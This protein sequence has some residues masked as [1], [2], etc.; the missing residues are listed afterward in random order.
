MTFP[1]TP[2]LPLTGAQSG[3][4]FDERLSSGRLAYNMADYLD[5]TGPLDE[6]LLR[7][8]LEM[9]L[10]EAECTRARFLEVDGMPAQRIEPLGELPLSTLDLSGEADPLAEA[11]RR[12]DEDLHQPF[13]LTGGLLFRSMLVRVA[14]GR[15]L[16]YVAMHHLLSDGYSRL[17]VYRRLSEIYGGL[18]DGGPLPGTPLP[19]LSVLLDNEAEYLGSRALERDRDFWAA[20]VPAGAEPVSLSAADPVA[21]S[22]FMRTTLEVDAEVATTLK[23]AAT[24]AGVTWPTF[25][26]AATA[27]YTARVTGNPDVL[28]T[29]AM[30]ARLTAQS[31]A[32]PGMVANYLPFPARV[33]A[34][35]TVAGLLG[36]TSK[37]LA[38]SLR[39]QRFPA[40]R[41]RK[42]MGLAGDDRRPFGPFINVLPQTP[43]FQLGAC[44]A[45]VNNLSTGIVDDLM[46]TVLDGANGSLELHMNGNPEL[47]R[48]E[49]IRDH[50]LRYERFLRRLAE[51]PAELP[52]G[53]LDMVTDAERDQLLVLG[54]GAVGVV[55]GGVVER[56]R[57]RAANDPAALAVV[58]AGNRVSYGELAAWADRVA[59]RLLDAGVGTDSLVGV[60]AEPGAAFLGVVLGVL[61]AGAAWI[62]LDV[63]APAVRSAGLLNDAGACCVVVGP[64]SEAV[65]G[66]VLARA[67]EGLAS[68]A[69]ED[70][71]LGDAFSADGSGALLEPA[72][73]VS[74]AAYVIFTSGST[75]RPKGAMVE[76]GGMLNHLAAKVEDLGLTSGDRVVWNAPVTFDVSVWQMLAP[77]MV[78]GVVEV[79]SREVAA[80]PDALFGLAGGGEVTV[81]EV[82]PSLLRAALDGWEL[83]GASWPGVGGLRWLVVTGEALPVDLCGRW[84]S[85]CEVPL[86][87]AYGPTECSDDV[88]HAVVRPGTE[89][90]SRVPIGGPVRNTQ[91]HVLGDELRPVPVGAVG[92]LYVGGAGVGRGY[93][94]DPGRTAGVFVADPF[95]GGGRRM[96]RTGDRVVWRADGQLEFVE[97]LDHQVKVRGHRVEL[98]EVEAALRDAP[99]VADAVVRA[100]TGEAGGAR[101]VAYVVAPGVDLGTVRAAAESVLPSYMVPGG[102][103]A[104]DAMPLTAHGK[105]D[106]AALP[107]PTGAAVLPAGG[108]TRRGPRNETERVLCD[109]FRG[110]LGLDAAGIDDSFFLLGGDSI[111]AIQ[112]VSRARA[113]GVVLT[114][115]DVFAHKTPAALAAHHANTATEARPQTRAVADDGVGDIEPTPIIAQLCEDLTDIAGPARE[116]SQYVLIRVPA[117]AA[118]ADVASVLQAL[119]DRHDTLRMRVGQ[120]VPGVWTLATAERGTLD[121]AALLTV[122]ARPA[123]GPEAFEQLVAAEAEAART[124]LAPQDGVM[125]QAV[126]FDRAPDGLG[127]LLLL[128]HH[129]VI[130]GV[131]W[132]ILLA[133]LQAAWEAAAAGREPAPEEV[134]TSYRHWASVL[135]RESRGADRTAELAYWRAQ[136]AGNPDTFGGRRLDPALD[137]YGRAGRL[138]LRLPA[139]VT[140]ELLTSVVAAFHGE[141]NDVLLAALTLAV[142]DWRRR[143]APRD[144]HRLVVELEGHGREEMPEETDLSRTVGWFTSVFPVSLDPGI[145]DA[146]DAWDAGPAL[147]TVVKR[148]KEQLRA[149]PERGIGHGMLRYL[150]PQTAR[151]LSLAPPHVGFNYLGR[152]KAGDAAGPWTMDGGD[153]VVGTGV[154]PDMPV[155][156]S[157]A[158]T[159]VTED[160]ADGPRLVADW[161]WADGVLS[162][163]DVEE[164]A[165]GWFR[166]L[167]ALVRH[168]ELPAPGGRTPSDLP[169]VPLSQ[170]EIEE[171]E[172]S[173]G[174]LTDVLP[175]TAL[176]RGMLFQAQLDD[177]GTD[178]YTLQVTAD[179]DGH[180]DAT[181]LETAMSAVLRRHPQ[182]AAGFRHR[183]AGEPVAVQHDGLHVPL[184]RADLADL[185]DEEREA[186]LAR[187]AGTDRRERFDLARPPLMRWTLV[188]LGPDRHRLVWTLHHIL[189]DGW[190][191]PV[192]VKDLLTCYAHGGDAG[193][194]PDALP[195]RAYLAWL[196]DRDREAARASWRGALEGMTEPVQL[197][198]AGADRVPV[199]PETVPLRLTEA[200]T[201]ALTSVAA[202]RGLT[203]NTL[204]QGCWAVLLGR[205][206]GRQDVLFGSIVSTRPAGL[207]GVETIV[208]PFL[209]TL[210]VRAVLPP[211]EPAGAFLQRLQD[212]QS[213]LRDTDHLGLS[214]MLSGNPDLA[215]AGEPFDTAIVFENFPMA[216]ATELSAGPDLRVTAA[217]ARDARHYPLSLVVQPGPAL[218][219]RFDY[220]PDLLERGAVAGIADR[221]RRLLL[222]LGERPERP[223]ARL[224]VLTPDES[225]L[226]E[227]W[228]DTERPDATALWGGVVERVRGFAAANPA[229]PA[230]AYGQVTSSYAEL[231]DR[232]DAVA[233]RLADAGAGAGSLV[234]VL[235]EP[236]PAFV[237]VVLGVLQAGAAWIP[238]DVTA[239]AVRSAGLLNDAGACCVVV[240][241]G[242]GTTADGVLA[243]TAPGLTPVTLED[244]FHGTGD[245]LLEPVGGASDAAYVIFTSGSTGRPKGAMVERGGMLNHLAAKVEDLGLTSGDRVVWNAPVTFD[246]SVWQ[247]L[248]P[249]M[250][251]GVVEVVSREVAADPDA[252]FGLAGGG[253]V[254]VL[255]VVPSL[256]RAALD[257]WELSGASWPGVGGLRWLVV[258]GEALPVDLCGR[259]WS[260]CEVPL[261]NAYGPTEC[262]DDVTHAVV[263]PGTEM[264]SRVPIGG[265]VRNTQL[266]VLGDELRP[267]P[268]G[269]VGEL[270]VGG[271][272]VGRGYVGDPGR[273]AGVFVADPFA[274]GGRRMYRTGDRVVWRAD[275]QLEFVE[276]LDHQV[277]V[278]G[279]RVELGEVEAALREAPGV[280]DAV[281]RAVTGEAGGARLVAYVVAPGVDLG[282]VRAAAESVLPSYMVPGGWVA[283]DAMPLTAHGKVDRAALPE[284]T[285]AVTVPG[286]GVRRAPE[287]E[288]ERVLCEVFRSVLGLDDVG[289]DDNFFL[290]GG[291]S[292]TAIQVVG[293]A[294][295]MGVVLTPRDVFG[296]RTPAA[297]AA[298]H[299]STA[300]DD[301][302][303]QQPS[304]PEPEPLLLLDEDEMDELDYELES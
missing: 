90:A 258:T 250:V 202:A 15:Q 260:L 294:R 122:A 72:G 169:L 81:L 71:F 225:G 21:G 221:F 273:T 226:L 239:P 129:T 40:E 302:A 195:F 256:L 159:A 280:V 197:C 142:G 34:G 84:W 30:T 205:L 56:V 104:M 127:R 2:A 6:A 111:T 89:M 162:H 109:V 275:G 181:A 200:E 117:G 133:D 149:L 47:Y 203:A 253:E 58:D 141:I 151:L 173:A 29:L 286:T 57:E 167:R 251:G 106:R 168:L 8:A 87:N 171:I 206:T 188:R 198:A 19:P 154:H 235:A 236:G 65:S 240:G 79:V 215:A 36:A 268:V 123:A 279:H 178:L 130:D 77:L 27:A 182:L 32:V 93:V 213:A 191:M 222:D 43:V 80:D 139:D 99:G 1:S 165:E 67:A 218:E 284:P 38:R 266:H 174:A 53:R 3:I 208:G 75:G 297:L 150:N 164:I 52:L 11:L 115:R 78:G 110:V 241:P 49:E 166:A 95:A 83:S 242:C 179:L 134:P 217:G 131:S 262:S 113:Q 85:L 161:L 126:L 300:A 233:R 120:P 196:A 272:G 285:G 228:N 216:A 192:L 201:A 289:A 274:G 61:Q 114:P 211:A 157:L 132:R 247:M 97:R 257:G 145:F 259:W 232:A 243:H 63:T 293:R 48:P 41:I 291:D 7:R 155:R 186:E 184:R 26:I 237:A 224:D 199:E 82:V 102:W 269:A 45:R 73:A 37:S 158:V 283:M 193:S 304:S 14:D 5:V 183:E 18:V 68:V 245:A 209:N 96:Y 255:E 20:H 238:L 25:A 254:T 98:G 59:R 249:L 4:W 35:T 91:L 70:G 28:L 287:N 153:S 234:G 230:V 212:E 292:I 148:V 210:P 185:A 13:E 10:D 180:V 100:V 112:V 76:R 121:A 281:V 107:E 88:T 143:T 227:K 190:S 9:V 55:W 270:Y 60:L 156:H 264:A 187:L 16:L 248:A 194:L 147:A 301:S 152:F 252:L 101:L 170:E 46:I 231:A 223:L 31:R 138:R 140:A 282:T 108:A 92:E 160:G 42:S 44:E 303:R 103:V 64:G 137:T 265:P 207:A 51:A 39:H 62:P 219:V 135:A 246:V 288:T 66:E 296:H 244:G 276:R 189:I 105:V 278:R 124:R 128:A 136:I 144:G 33:E 163:E 94:G 220:A 50:L 177:G 74:D 298:H 146:Q 24:A 118:A 214:E 290:L 299:V 119:L 172:R 204:I 69:V 86:V 17:A 125:L 22:A 261:V 116:Y 267:V 277:K 23:E 175:L 229:A 176:Q 12:F 295:A 263:R 54:T 271:A